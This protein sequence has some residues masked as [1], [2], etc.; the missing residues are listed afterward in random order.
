VV[1]APWHNRPHTRTTWYEPLED[2]PALDRAVHWVL[3]NPIVFLNTPGDIHVLPKVLES[4][5]RFEARPSEDAMRETLSA[6][7]MEP[8]FV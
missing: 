3:G 8:L 7:A 5:D 1:R 6:Q 2:Q 4:A